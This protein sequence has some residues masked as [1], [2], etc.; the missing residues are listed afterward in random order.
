M[1][2]MPSRKPSNAYMTSRHVCF[3]A[4]ARYLAHANIPAT[5]DRWGHWSMLTNCMTSAPTEVARVAPAQKWANASNW[6]SCIWSRINQISRI[7]LII[8]VF[9]DA[10]QK[11][12]Y[13][14]PADTEHITTSTRVIGIV[15][16]SCRFYAS[17][18]ITFVRRLHA[19]SVAIQ[20]GRSIWLHAAACLW[21]YATPV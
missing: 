13:M 2:N 5:A 7:D 21:G 20:T 15:A 16:V 12:R 1:M 3:S 18:F 17:S 4:H 10:Q 9:E 19:L 8:V 6:R 11:H 14:S